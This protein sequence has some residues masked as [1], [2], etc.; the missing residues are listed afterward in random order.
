MG[1]IPQRSILALES[2][3]YLGRRAAVRYSLSLVDCNSG[4][5]PATRKMVAAKS[6]QEIGVPPP[7]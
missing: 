5:K 4:C 7:T 1:S 2:A 6:N 3:E